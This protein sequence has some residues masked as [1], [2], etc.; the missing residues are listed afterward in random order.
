MRGGVD[1][2][3][4]FEEVCRVIAQE[5]AIMAIVDGFLVGTMGI[6]KP[7]WW[8]N[9]TEFLTDRWHFVLP[10]HHHG[11]VDEALMREAEML[12]DSSGLEFIDQG[13]IRKRRGKLL[14]MPRVYTPEKVP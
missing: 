7:T 9:T 13:K 2:I 1:P 8:Y 5:A 3:K 10:E 6:I 14:M 4:S 12:A 11:P